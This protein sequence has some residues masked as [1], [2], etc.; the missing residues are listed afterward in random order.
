[1]L[2]NYYNVFGK[3]ISLFNREEQH[4]K[5]VVAEFSLVRSRGDERQH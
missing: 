5:K 2:M 1:M 3:V 4:R